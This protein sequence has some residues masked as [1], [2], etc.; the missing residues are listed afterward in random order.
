M[1]AMHGKNDFRFENACFS[2]NLKGHQ[3]LHI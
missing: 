3:S 2:G 1:H